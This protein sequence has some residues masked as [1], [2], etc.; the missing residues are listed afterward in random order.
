M[1]AVVFD[2]PGADAVRQALRSTPNMSAVNA[3]EVAARLHEDSWTPAEIALVL[4]DLGIEI[5]PF[6]RQCALLSGHYRP[7]TRHVG[8]GLGDR[9]CLATAHQQE[10]PALT[11]DRAWEA[12]EIDVKVVCI[13]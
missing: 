8:L 7:A 13:R 1:L 11:A 3:A 6:D 5:L 4:D 10:R 12:L 2:E 9:A